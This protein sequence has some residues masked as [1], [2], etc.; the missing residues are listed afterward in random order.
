MHPVLISIGSVS[1]SSFGFFLSLA[2]L[3]SVYIIW[4]LCRVYD[5]NEEKI[6]DISLLTFFG[7]LIGARIYFVLANFSAFHSISQ[8][9]LI[10][11][12]PG[13]YFWGGIIGGGA[14][15]ILLT[16]RFKM[17]FWHIADF[18]TVGI[19]AGLILGTFGC[20]LGSCESGI[21][22]NLPIA[23]SQ[24]GLVGARF[25]IQ[26]LETL[27]FL[28]S[29]IYLWQIGLKFHYNG[30]VLSVGLFLLGLIKFFAE[31]FRSNTTHLTAFLTLGQVFALALILLS[32]VIH[33]HQTKRSLW[34]DVK[35]FFSP[36][37]RRV[38]LPKLVKGCYNFLT[39]I[40][41]KLHRSTKNV[42]V[43][44][45]NLLRNINVKPKPPQY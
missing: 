36:R 27:A 18:V 22:S 20:L 9:V 15:L 39:N 8:I 16:R 11:R 6:L 14:A 25:P 3:V 21:P 34:S 41:F 32:F 43:Q 4:R 37:F 1:I 40:R 7:G 10:N 19:F 35:V 42:K 28:L 23:V 17:D 5:I 2:F 13:L 24:I 12:Y 38:I 33:Y 45:K 26:F 29:F 31:F 44:S 30:R